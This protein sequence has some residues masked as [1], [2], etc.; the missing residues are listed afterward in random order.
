MKISTQIEVDSEI[1][2]ER[3]AVEYVAKAG[4]DA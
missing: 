3:R 2:G 4:F 1:I